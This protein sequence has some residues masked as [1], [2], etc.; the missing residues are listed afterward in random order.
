MILTTTFSLFFLFTL[1]SVALATGGDVANIIKKPDEADGSHSKK[2]STET[3]EDPE[4]EFTIKFG[5]FFK[6]QT[7]K[8]YA[9][10][11]HTGRD[12]IWDIIDLTEGNENGIEL[13]PTSTLTIKRRSSVQ[14]EKING[15]TLKFKKTGSEERDFVEVT[16]VEIKPVGK[17]G[18]VKHFKNRKYLISDE[19]VD[20]IES[21]MYTF[22]IKFGYG[23]EKHTGKLLATL[24]NTGWHKIWDIITLNEEN[25]EGIELTP[26]STLTFNEWSSVQ[27]QKTSKL[28]IKWI[29]TGSEEGDVI[30]IDKVV[31]KPVG[32]DGPVKE[33][34]NNKPLAQYEE[35]DFVVVKSKE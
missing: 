10:L 30:K 28:S 31:V 21:T 33:F 9:T 6:K 25:V 18:P 15:L 27:L 12:N 22:T 1:T 34:T 20:F 35:V 14:L 16:N 19:E 26:G 17:T 2:L 13:T 3:L 4:Y 7:G 8:L 32:Q 29:K 23:F 5:Y 24:E 11:K